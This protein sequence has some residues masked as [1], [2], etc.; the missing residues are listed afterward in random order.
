M[1]RVKSKKKKSSKKNSSNFVFL[2]III[3]FVLFF[4]I[5]FISTPKIK[6]IGDKEIRIQA[7]ES[8]EEKGATCKAFFK[9]ITQEI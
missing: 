7:G 5:K 2:F 8:Y 4:A 3:V 6:I 9:D 1:N